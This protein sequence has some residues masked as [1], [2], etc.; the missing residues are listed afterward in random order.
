MGTVE[1]GAGEVA[2]LAGQ[3]VFGEQ[4]VLLSLAFERH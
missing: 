3:F 4:Y 1:R 2:D